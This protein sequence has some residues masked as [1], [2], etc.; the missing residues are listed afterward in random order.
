M[1]VQVTVDSNSTGTE[2]NIAGD[3]LKQLA[4][5][6]GVTPLIAVTPIAVA[7]IAVEQPVATAQVEP[8]VEAPAATVTRR[9]RTKAEIEA[10]EQVG[11]EQP[12]PTQDVTATVTTEEAPVPVV[13]EAVKESPSEPVVEQVPVDTGEKQYSA[14]E[15]QLLASDA[16]RRAGPDKVK[17]LIANFGATRIAELKPEQLQSFAA[18]VQAL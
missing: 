4:V 15:I 11:N 7:P 16:A 9:R 10:A 3:F 1:Q 14:G 6:R 18:K 17:A 12:A 5:A 8:A 2:L 13:E